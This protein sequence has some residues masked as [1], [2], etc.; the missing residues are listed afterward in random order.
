MFPEPPEFI[1]HMLR[2]RG[3]VVH[4]EIPR[5]TTNQIV[6]NKDLRIRYLL[7]EIDEKRFKQLLQQREKRSSKKR[8]FELVLRMLGNV[9]RDLIANFNNAATQEEALSIDLEFQKLCEYTNESLKAVGKV[10]NCK[11]PYVEGDTIQ[12]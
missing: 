6:D 7:N 8:E 2:L 10:F 12:Y 3:H 9:I 11:T 1:Y 4:V 5:F